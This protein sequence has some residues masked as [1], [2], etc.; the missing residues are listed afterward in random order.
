MADD[1]KILIVEDDSFLS[2]ILLIKFVKEGINSDLAVN[3]EEAVEKIK[4]GNKYDFVLL[5]LML[6]KMNGFEVLGFI[7]K[8]SKIKDVPV[9]ILSNLGQESDMKKALDGGATDFWIKASF[10]I[11][12]LVGR[13]KEMM[14]K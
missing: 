12:D 5:D 2:K 6:P 1:K 14:V 11:D 9:V 4:S 3:G 13:V 8:E 10:K 7:R